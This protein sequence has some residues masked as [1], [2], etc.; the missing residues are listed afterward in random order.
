LGLWL[1]VLSGFETGRVPGCPFR[2]PRKNE[3]GFL[4]GEEYEEEEADVTKEGVDLNGLSGALD[5]NLFLKR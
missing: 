4:Y 3:F 5:L 2:P 1:G